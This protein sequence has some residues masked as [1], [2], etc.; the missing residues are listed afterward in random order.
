MSLTIPNSEVPRAGDA[1]VGG[2]DALGT[3]E[4]EKLNSQQMSTGNRLTL[5]DRRNFAL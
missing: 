4:D 2:I 1:G 5:P 3:S